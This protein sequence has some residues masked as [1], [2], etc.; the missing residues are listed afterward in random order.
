[1]LTWEPSCKLT[2][3]FRLGCWQKHFHVVGWG[4]ALDPFPS[5]V[6]TK[7]L[8]YG[9]YKSKFGQ[10]NYWQRDYCVVQFP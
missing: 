7:A 5:R 8:V 6:L 3:L 1:V 9:K 4:K 10:E 2:V